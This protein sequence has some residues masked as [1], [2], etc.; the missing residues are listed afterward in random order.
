MAR[1]PGNA[2]WTALSRAVVPDADETNPPEDA[3]HMSFAVSL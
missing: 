3:P 1:E 2:A